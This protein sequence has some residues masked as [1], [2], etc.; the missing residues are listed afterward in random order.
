MVVMYPL[1]APVIVFKAS[2]TAKYRVGVFW[3]VS[4]WGALLEI[5]RRSGPV[6]VLRSRPKISGLHPNTE[7]FT[8]FG[9]SGSVQYQRA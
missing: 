2:H 6:R 8:E 1:L 5:E 9:R 7:R 4:D 3:R